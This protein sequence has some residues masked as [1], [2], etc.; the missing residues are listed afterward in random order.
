MERG[1]LCEQLKEINSYLMSPNLLLMEEPRLVNAA[2][3]FC[4]AVVSVSEL[5]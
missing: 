2:E 3:V 5:F 4:P 1:S